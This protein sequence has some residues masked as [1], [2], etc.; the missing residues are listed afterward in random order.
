MVN[1]KKTYEKV[2]NGNKNL[3]YKEI[4]GMLEWL[5]Y[6]KSEKGKTS[7]SRVAFIKDGYSPIILHKPHPRNTLLPYQLT[8]IKEVLLGKEQK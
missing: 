1:H 6:R 7:G 3:T 4:V 5:D 8:E 2:M